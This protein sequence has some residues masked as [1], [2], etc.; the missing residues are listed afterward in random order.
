MSW[1]GLSER[2]KTRLGGL[3]GFIVLLPMIFLGNQ[4]R[5]FVHAVWNEHWVH[6]DGMQV[7]AIVTQVDSKSFLD[8]RFTING[9]DYTGNGRRDW[10]DERNHPVGVGDKVTAFVS[11]SHPWLSELDTSR[12]AWIGLPI[13]VLIL[14]FELLLLG[15]L[16]DAI[17]R[18]VFG[19]TIHNGKPEGS[20]F[21]LMF[22]GAMVVLMI[23]SALGM[24]KNRR[25]RI[26]ITRQ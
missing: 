23:M 11:A 12:S 15:V 3:V 26:F 7:S 24:R 13:A 22:A 10:E 1:P 25:T 17:V 18:L 16:L 14:I 20:I 19:I 8:Y 6:K 21:V 4:V 5:M 2:A 9:K